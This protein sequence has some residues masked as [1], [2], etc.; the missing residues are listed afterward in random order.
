MKTKTSR[1]GL[2]LVS[3]ILLLALLPVG[4]LITK[5]WAVASRDVASTMDT[6]TD[7]RN[8]F[9]FKS[10]A[11]LAHPAAGPSATLPLPPLCPD[12][13]EPVGNKCVLIRDV[14]LER[15]L[16]LSSNMTL[17]CQ[18][19]VIRP[20]QGSPLIVNPP[21][22]GI[23]LNNAQ[24]VRIENCGISGFDFGIFAINTKRTFRPL[25]QAVP[26][27]SFEPI[28]ILRN[29]ITSQY[30]GV[31]LMS[32]DEAVIEKNI[33]VY[34]RAAGRALYVG[35]NS[36]SNKVI[37]NTFIAQL[38][39]GVPNFA[40][41]VPGPESAANPK[42]AFPLPGPGA[43]PGVVIITQIEGLEP[44]LLNA[45]INRQ[46]FQLTTSRSLVADS[47]FSEG[48]RLEGNRIRF[49]DV[50]V[51]GVILSIPEGTLVARNIIG[52]GGDAAVR[53]GSQNEISRIF[54]G[55][56]VAKPNRLC[57]D[58]G[59]CNIQGLDAAG[60]T[61]TCTGQITRVVS[62][63]SR[64][65]RIEENTITGPLGSG[66][67][68]AGQMT[69]IISNTITGPLR[70]PTTG[71]GIRLI[72][73]NGIETTTVLGN[74]VSKVEVALNFLQTI[75]NLPA[76]T[77]GAEIAFNDFTEYDTAVLVSGVSTNPYNLASELSVSGGGNFWGTSCREGL[78]ANAV[79][80]SDGT[81]NSLIT[82][83]HPFNVSVAR[84]F[85]GVLP[86]TCPQPPVPVP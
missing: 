38:V 72:G 5:G 64:H 75:Q 36:D 15:T 43:A 61:D 45:V 68:T 49:N 78:S 51:D 60:G 73:K 86:S 70:N 83:S 18:G 7:V 56:C 39:P 16:I 14:R 79:K 69:T 59:G 33:I 57:L 9:T 21:Q 62:W 26:L 34:T 27:P 52:K 10:D 44:T 11:L 3:L 4:S 31:S 77:F 28:R 40:F 29:I 22:V 84:I 17:D 48:N 23:F 54:P 42:V 19:H 47:S 20:V 80:N 6:P 63:I 13:T 53:V 41:R 85:R 2:S 81:F 74:T 24:N 76:A 25:V 50:P 65:N 37:S 66:I 8:E 82:D 67:S 35:R 58:N 46:L 32:V 12:P 55:T 71:A 1:R 30:T